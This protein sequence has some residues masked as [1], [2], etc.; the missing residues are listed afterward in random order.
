MQST[1]CK[2]HKLQGGEPSIRQAVLR[3]RQLS[4]ARWRLLMYFRAWTSSVMAEITFLECWKIVYQWQS[5]MCTTFQRSFR[6]SMIDT[7]I[8]DWWIYDA[9]SM[10][11]QGELDCELNSRICLHKWRE[12]S[13]PELHLEFFLSSPILPLLLILCFHESRNDG[14]HRHDI[15]VTLVKPRCCLTTSKKN[16]PVGSSIRT[17]CH[18]IA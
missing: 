1:L 9:R 16:A 15:N 2:V 12:H 10:K 8:L 6:M 17:C 18:L 7:S 14:S 3:K 4:H 11:E 13:K 5:L